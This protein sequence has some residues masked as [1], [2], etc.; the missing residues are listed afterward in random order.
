MIHINKVRPCSSELISAFV[1][2][3]FTGKTRQAL[4]RQVAMQRLFHCGTSM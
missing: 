1:R 3:T 2:G 4:H